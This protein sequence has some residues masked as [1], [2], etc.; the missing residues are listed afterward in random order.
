[1]TEPVPS[2]SR[3]T[4]GR[5]L[6]FVLLPALLGATITGAVL[7]V[8]LSGWTTNDVT[9]GIHMGYP[10]LQPR[11]YDASVS[12]TTQFASAAATRQ[13]GW[14]VLRTEP[15]KGNVEV[16]VPSGPFTD[17]LTVTITPEGE[18]S[19]VV[20]R[21]RSRVGIGDLG[22]NARHIRTLQ[23]AMDDKLPRLAQ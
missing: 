9:T 16:E 11:I 23:T 22:A 12:N 20:I 14:K 5:F 3:L 13:K 10:D 8:P 21:S 2:P 1:M 17:D 18:G 19:R 7:L 6:R 15:E 4:A